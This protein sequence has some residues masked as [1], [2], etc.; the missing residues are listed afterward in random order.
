MVKGLEMTFLSKLDEQALNKVVGAAQTRHANA[1]QT[2]QTAGQRP[3]HLLMLTSG[4]A[5]YYK[6]T[7]SGVEIVLH[8]LT[9]GDVVGLG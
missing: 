3:K 6:A 4:R 7:K 1:G 8:I 2:L 9:T 5:S